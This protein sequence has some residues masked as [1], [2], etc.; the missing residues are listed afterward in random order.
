MAVYEI[1]VNTAP[2]MLGNAATEA[3]LENYL[4]SLEDELWAR[5]PDAQLDLD[6]AATAVDADTDEECNE[7]RDVIAA[8][9]ER[10]EWL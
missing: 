2:E 6:A 1:A 4:D 5:Y 7:V 8:H 3:D 9:F 10:G